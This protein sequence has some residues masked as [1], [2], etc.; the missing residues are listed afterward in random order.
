MSKPFGL[1]I[2]FITKKNHAFRFAE[3]FSLN[4]LYRLG[5]RFMPWEKFFIYKAR[6]FMY[7]NE[8]KCTSNYALFL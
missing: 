3:F 1:Y 6:A 5:F 2:Y 4:S 7:I 8:Q